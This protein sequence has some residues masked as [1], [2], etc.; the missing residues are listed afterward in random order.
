MSRL[1]RYALCAAI[2]ASVVV[3]DQIVKRIVDRWLVLYES[4][5]IVPGLLGLTY[6]RNRGAAFGMFQNAAFPAQTVVLTLISL[7]ALVAVVFF[8]MRLPANRVLPRIGLSLVLG[9]AIGNLIDRV[10]LGYVIDFV[11]V[12]WRGY[13]WPTFNV[14]DSA[15]T[16]GVGLLLVDML[17]DS[18]ARRKEPKAADEATTA[19]RME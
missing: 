9:G 8:F 12:H 13:H 4:H 2:S 16:V 10:R 19:G 1:R 14:A 3:L 15:I 5:T 18:P 7:A 17:R 11:D 6:T